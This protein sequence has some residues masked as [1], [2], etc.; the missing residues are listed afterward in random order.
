[1]LAFQ[2]LFPLPASLTPDGISNLLYRASTQP[3]QLT[4]TPQQMFMSLLNHNQRFWLWKR[5]FLQEIPGLLEEWQRAR[6]PLQSS[7]NSGNLSLSVLHLPQNAEK[8]VNAACVANVWTLPS[9]SLSLIEFSK[10]AGHCLQPV[11]PSLLRRSSLLPPRQSVSSSA[12][13]SSPGSFLHFARN[14]FYPVLRTDEHGDKSIALGAVLH[15]RV[16]NFPA[17]MSMSPSASALLVVLRPTCFGGNSS[18]RSHPVSQPEGVL[19]IPE[20]LR[21]TD[22]FSLQLFLHGKL[23]DSVNFSI[24]DVMDDGAFPKLPEAPFYAQWRGDQVINRNTFLPPLS[25]DMPLTAITPKSSLQF[26][27]R[28]ALP[29]GS[30]VLFNEN[31]GQ[32][33]IWP[34]EKH[35]CALQ[36]P[37]EIRGGHTVRLY[38]YP[39]RSGQ[40]VSLDELYFVVQDNEMVVTSDS[41]H[42]KNFRCYSAEPFDPKA[43]RSQ[44]RSLPPLPDAHPLFDKSGQADHMTSE[45]RAA[46]LCL[47]SLR[48]H[49]TAGRYSPFRG[50]RAEESFPMDLDDMADSSPER[51]AANACDFENPTLKEN[52]VARAAVSLMIRRKR[53]GQW[54]PTNVAPTRL[55]KMRKC[56]IQLEGNKCPSAEV[57]V[58]STDEEVIK[59]SPWGKSSSDGCKQI[60]VEFD[61]DGQAYFFIVP[62]S[63]AKSPCEIRVWLDFPSTSVCIHEWHL[64]VANHKFESSPEGVAQSRIHHEPV[65]YFVFYSDTRAVASCRSEAEM[66]LLDSLY[67]LTDTARYS[68]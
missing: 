9:F 22:T 46:E 61:A 20:G 53:R 63:G 29:G 11:L 62:M 4:H 3:N 35:Y 30:V 13:T 12:N 15:Y 58:E 59:L 6:P 26:N 38:V 8:N 33:H 43:A 45:D 57:S 34:I 23:M 54:H 55:G 40:S 64:E 32:G 52:L 31:T 56:V 2:P 17:Y 51:A 5:N 50:K 68:V 14:A 21:P 7:S 42:S 65:H 25:K 37:D 48:R 41:P 47:A 19:K 16:D 49:S 39:D 24:S 10:S 44:V 28:W 60:T 67:M 1:M 66:Q 27:I 36:L 18:E